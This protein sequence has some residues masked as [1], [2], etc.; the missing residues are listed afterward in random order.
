[1]GFYRF[2]APVKPVERRH[3]NK[4]VFEEEFRGCYFQDKQLDAVALRQVVE[5]V[6]PKPALRGESNKS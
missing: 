2:D 1:M 5:Q 6:R 4:E 3:D